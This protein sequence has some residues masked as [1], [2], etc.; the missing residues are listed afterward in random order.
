[1]TNAQLTGI[2]KNPLY[3]KPVDLPVINILDGTFFMY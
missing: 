3:G 2:Q 1:M